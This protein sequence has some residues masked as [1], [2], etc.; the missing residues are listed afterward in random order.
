MAETS[1][2]ARRGRPKGSV[3][4]TERKRALEGL[5][6]AIDEACDGMDE[7]KR[8]FV[9]SEFASYEWNCNRMDELERMLKS[10]TLEPDAR[11]DLRT[12]RHQLVTESGQLFSHLMRQL[13]DVEPKA[14]ADPMAEFL[15]GGK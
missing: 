6:K 5:A 15:P 4:K 1:A 12:E 10:K 13:K 9:K 7:V 3:N 8:G 11:K 2:P 14:E